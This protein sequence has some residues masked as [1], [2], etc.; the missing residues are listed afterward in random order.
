MPTTVRLAVTGM[1]RISRFTVRPP[2][3]DES[4]CSAAV[5]GPVDSMPGQAWYADRPNR[6]RL[7]EVPFGDDADEP[8]D[9]TV[10]ADCECSNLCSAHIS[11][12]LC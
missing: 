10:F 4:S 5:Y 6:P 11:R 1:W 2:I 3:L 8:A 9:T 12:C 7:H